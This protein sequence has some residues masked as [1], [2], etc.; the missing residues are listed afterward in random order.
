[1]FHPLSL[2]YLSPLFGR[3]GWVGWLMVCLSIRSYG[4]RL[5]VF[6]RSIHNPRLDTLD[7]MRDERLP[8]MYVISNACTCYGMTIEKCVDL[9]VQ[10]SQFD[11][12]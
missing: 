7:R 6:P 10:K 1:M 5:S 8:C 12:D 11:A 3:M 9:Q 4:S 2:S